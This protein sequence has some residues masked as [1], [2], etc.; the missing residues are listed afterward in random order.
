MVND[1][2]GTQVLALPKL[3]LQFLTV[4]DYLLR[5]FILYRLESAYEIR[6]DIV[7]A[8]KRMGPKMGLRGTVFA[9]WARMALQISSLS[10]DE[11]RIIIYYII[12]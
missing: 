7:D 9:G 8:V 6:E 11:V 4:H 1:Y 5:N 10:I 12:R 2:N 3:N